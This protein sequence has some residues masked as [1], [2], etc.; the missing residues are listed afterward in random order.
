[1]LDALVFS[2]VWVAT[3]AVAL[4]AAA[5]LAMQT[6]PAATVMALAFCGTLVVYNVDRL[7]DLARDRETAPARS[8][9]V[10]THRQALTLVT[11][12]AAAASGALALAAGPR[13]IA[14]LAP[15][16]L[17]G[18]FHRRL[19]RFGWW[20]PFYVSLAWTGVVVGLPAVLAR[21]GT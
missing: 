16:L 14:L 11:G 2:S 5:A 15:V 12:L 1:M 19:K 8:H 4:S 21:V 9:F 13:V 6:Q 7:R 10:E 17:A 20:K 18:L 3:A